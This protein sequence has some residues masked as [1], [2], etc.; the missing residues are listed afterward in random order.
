MTLLL[1]YTLKRWAP[2]FPVYVLDFGMT[3][4]Q[5]AFLSK[6][7]TVLTRPADVPPNEH[8]SYYK[9]AIGPYL[10]D[11]EWS[12]MAWIDCDMVALGPVGERINALIAEMEQ[13]NS[14]IA[15]CLDD[16]GT[17]AELLATGMP[18]E[19][20]A[21]AMR[22][23]GSDFSAPYYNAGLYVCRSPAF[24]DAWWE[25]GKTVPMHLCFDQ[26]IFNLLV[27][28]RGAPKLL[29]AWEWNLHGANL[30]AA[31]VVTDPSGRSTL[32]LGNERPL[33]LHP[34]SPRA[35]DVFMASDLKVAGYTLPGYLKFCANP[36]VQRLQQLLVNE[37]VSQTFAELRASGVMG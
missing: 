36:A 3:E 11:V 25:R 16:T 7:A 24:L 15:A 33:L 22:V 21:D 29:P 10:A 23:Q 35:E 30:N 9:A 17:V 19:P 20:F 1:L 27:Q 4:V 37:Y 2:E 12:E 8:S 34:T 18:L 14:E 32:M 26:N 13:N 6:R 28:R 5:K 31:R